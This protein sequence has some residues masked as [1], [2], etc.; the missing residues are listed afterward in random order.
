MNEDGGAEL[1]A[2]TQELKS[3]YYSQNMDSLLLYC[4]LK[5]GVAR[6]RGVA[7]DLPMG[8]DDAVKRDG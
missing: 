6:R 2:E 7:L 1:N 4:G 8:I 3:C 5:G